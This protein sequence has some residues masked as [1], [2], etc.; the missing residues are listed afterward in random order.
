M[1]KKLKKEAKRIYQESLEG[2]LTEDEII[3][4]GDWLLNRMSI[5]D[6]TGKDHDKEAVQKRAKKSTKRTRSTTA[7]GNARK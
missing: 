3:L 4:V 2:T 7:V 6:M 1:R 5:Q